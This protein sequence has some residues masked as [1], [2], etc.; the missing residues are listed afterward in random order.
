[1]ENP[2]LKLLGESIPVDKNVIHISE[3]QP[4]ADEVTILLFCKEM[5]HLDFLL[6]KAQ[7]KKRKYLKR[8]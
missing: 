4:D 3:Y 8:R 2:E 5:L 1:M 7:L 6:P